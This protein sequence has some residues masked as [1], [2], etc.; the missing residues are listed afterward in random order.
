MY[1]QTSQTKA[2]QWWWSC[3]S[4][5]QRPQLLVSTFPHDYTFS[6][7]CDEFMMDFSSFFFISLRHSRGCAQVAKAGLV[8]RH[9][10]LPWQHMVRQW[11]YQFFLTSC[12]CYFVPLQC[13]STL[14]SHVL[15]L[16]F[17]YKGLVAIYFCPVF[18]LCCFV[19]F[20]AAN[21]QFPHWC[22]QS[23]ILIRECIFL[24]TNTQ[25]MLT[26]L[27]INPQL[28]LFSPFALNYSARLFKEI[29]ERRP[30]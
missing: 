27:P 24:T 16:V 9:V 26:L 23:F 14:I 11:T 1:R 7:M 29:T 2:N 25:S 22:Y 17:C 8:H 18:P 5:N 19:L 15:V 20:A 28:K 6:N 3:S 4:L 13:C 21:T 30:F 12:Y 10:L